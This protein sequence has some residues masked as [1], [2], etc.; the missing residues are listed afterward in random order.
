MKMK[1]LIS[2]VTLLALSTLVLAACGDKKDDKKDEGTKA[3]SSE[4]VKTESSESKTSDSK[5]TAKAELKDG[6]Y[7]LE[8]KNENNG[9]RTVFTIVVKDGKIAESKY[10]N[11]N[12]DGKS[13]TGD[14]EYNKMMKEKSGTSPDI[15]IPELN[16]ALEEAQDPDVVDV[17]SGATH[18]S[19]SFKDY[20]KQLVAAAEK[21]DTAKIE[22]D[23]KV[24]K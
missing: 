8:E 5:S 19:N 7:T 24:E 6:E 17:V 21:G 2:S 13:K 12:K 23:N 14:A 10:D 1:K 9:Y 18:S 22:I 20:A 11:I 4:V 3:S 16:K 15:F